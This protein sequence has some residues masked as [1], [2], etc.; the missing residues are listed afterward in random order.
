M[1]I[2]P[3]RVGWKVGL[4]RGEVRLALTAAELT[5]LGAGLYRLLRQ[6][7]DYRVAQVGWDPEGLVDLA[8]SSN[9]SGPTRS[10]RVRWMGLCLPRVCIINWSPTGSNHSSSASSG[11]RI[12]TSSARRLPPAGRRAPSGHRARLGQVVPD[13]VDPGVAAE[14]DADDVGR[15]A[16]VTCPLSCTCAESSDVCSWAV[17]CASAPPNARTVGFVRSG[18]AQPAKPSTAWRRIKSMSSPGAAPPR[19]LEPAATIVV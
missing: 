16:G 18:L 17:V 11:F 15:D 1:S 14:R 2:V 4:D 5:E 6:L 13:E 19:G 10:L 3:A 8:R 12:E 7:T 9:K